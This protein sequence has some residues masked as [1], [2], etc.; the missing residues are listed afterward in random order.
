MAE[1]KKAAPKK[2]ANNTK[3]IENNKALAAIGYLGILFL[4]PLLAAKE[5]P[6]AQFHAKQSVNLFIIGAGASIIAGIIPI[7]GWFI[8]API[9][10]IGWLILSIL[11]LV[12]ALNGKEEKLPLVGD[13]QIIK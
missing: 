3:D 10:S 5:S 8:I 13:F 6:Y 11:G 1:E 4:V 7:L 12:N 2:A 9:V